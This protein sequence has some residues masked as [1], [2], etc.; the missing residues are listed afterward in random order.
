[1]FQ[2]YREDLE[3]PLDERYIHRFQQQ[4]DGS[5]IIFTCFTALLAILDDPGVKAFEDDTTFKRIE[6]EIN[7]WE[8]V[9]FYNAVER[10]KSLFSSDIRSDHCAAVTLARAYIN[11]SDT[12]FFERLFDI[13]RDI[14]REAT[15]LD[16]RFAR[17]MPNGNLLVMN[18]DMEAAQTLGAAL[19][20]MKTNVPSFSGIT[21]LDP[22]VFATFFVKF[23]GGHAM[24][25]V[26]C[27][28]NS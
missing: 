9:T 5:L 16:V 3:K 19:S 25:C 2:L 11:R 22:Q 24:R 28:A 1:M 21:T 7:E 15:G 12:K 17:F 4:A 13:F 10:G 14:K 6:G 18:A 23:C 26:S 27:L 20:F 8:V